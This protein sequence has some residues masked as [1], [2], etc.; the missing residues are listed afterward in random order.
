MKALSDCIDDYVKKGFGS[1]NKN[2]FEVWIFGQL[3][4]M[5]KYAGKTNY[6]LSLALRIPETKV[7]RLRYE[8][9]LKTAVSTEDYKLQVQKLLQNA[10]LRSDDKKILFQVEDVMLK[11][12]ISSLLKKEGRMIDNSF[13][14]EVLVLH[15]A[16][17][18][19][20]VKAVYDDE[21][22]N[23]LIKK[24]QEITKEKRVTWDKIMEW[25][26][27]GAVSGAAG[28]LVNSVVDLTPMGMIKLIKQG[29]KK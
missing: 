14:P 19:Y 21:E 17:Y 29:F 8:S 11:L 25:V 13:N 10:Q 23:D 7:K 20:L 18:E 26:I 1:M 28:A 2:D 16:D 12:Y 4:S 9:A 22:V 3:I 6:E 15:L 5:G 24:A 27:S